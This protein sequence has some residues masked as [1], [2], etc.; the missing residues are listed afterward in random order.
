MLPLSLPALAA[1]EQT[2]GL[3]TKPN[4]VEQVTQRVSDISTDLKLQQQKLDFFKERHAVQDKRIDDLSDSLGNSVDF[5]GILITVIGILMTIV[6]VYFSFRST[7]E[8][9]LAA[10]DEARK[11]IEAQAKNI[12][13]SW[14]NK[15][16]K[17]ELTKKIDDALEPEI[18][19]ALDQIHKKADGELKKLEE[20]R[21]KAS[22]I[23]DM[24]SQAIEQHKKAFNELIVP[25]VNSGKPLDIEQM[26]EVEEA[27]RK[28]KS[29]PPN[30]YSFEDWIMLGKRAL[31]SKKYEVAL[32][33]FIEAE[34]VSSE[35]IEL[36]HALL[37]K[38]ITLGKMEKNAE[39][40]IIY[41][42]VVLRFGEATEASLREQVAKALV[43]KGLSLGQ[44]EK[45]AEAIAIYDEVVR[46]FSE[47]TEA[48]L[49]EQVAKALVNKGLTLGRVG[50]H[51]EE[52]A[53]Y[54]EIVRRFGEATEAPLRE[55]VARAL[56][57]KGFN[58]GRMGEHQEEIANYDEIVRRFG[59]ATEA[60]LREQVANALL[61]KGLTFGQ[62]GMYQE[63]IAN[64]GEVVR[65]FGEAT[66]APLR[67]QVAI[68]LVHKGLTLGQMRKHQEAIA[69][70][71]EIV[72]RFGEATEAPLREQVAI[73]LQNK[74]ILLRKNEQNKEKE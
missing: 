1:S 5:Y 40:I 60:P 74:N 14:L 30:D 25:Q 68:A 52:I 51:Q 56:L 20:E 55:Q 36:A 67:E 10:K 16:G 33:H 13:E 23:N 42:E 49:R 58:L 9:V 41:N 21:L 6:V 72:R 43:N 11:E 7:K 50:E 59:E 47:A 44:M 34:N 3:S 28:L 65:R 71:D 22:M 19:K 29:K 63:A 53:N 48:S 45:N 31:E 57:F 73:A 32:E 2:A 18:A 70:Y 39:A 69:N 8:A 61:I 15:D 26:Q 46:R 17:Q 37:N 24:A 62:T 38:G 54:D 27:A 4:S 12:I 64:Y 35:P 66:E